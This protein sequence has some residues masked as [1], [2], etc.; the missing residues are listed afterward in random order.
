VSFAYDVT[1]LDFR[2]YFLLSFY[3]IKLV[4]D[5]FD[6]LQRFYFLKRMKSLDPF[7]PFFKIEVYL[8]KF[9][10]LNIN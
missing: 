1:Y 2:I 7:Y 9:Q 6:Y 8:I 3:L 5:D 10:K 4:I